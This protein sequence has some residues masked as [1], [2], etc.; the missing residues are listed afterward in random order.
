M[1]KCKISRDQYLKFKLWNNAKTNRSHMTAEEYH[2]WSYL[3]NINVTLPFPYIWIRQGVVSK[4]IVDFLCPA[5]KLGLEVDGSSHYYKAHYDAVRQRFLTREGYEILHIS[6][7]DT[8]D[9]AVLKQFM[10]AV[11]LKT[12]SKI[13]LAQI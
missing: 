1:V 4:Y 7:S 10:H 9:E 8:Y 13:V 5:V 3:Q 12:I 6:N 11:E 2:V